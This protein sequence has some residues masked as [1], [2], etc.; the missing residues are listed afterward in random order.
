[1]AFIYLG[2][3]QNTSDSL[4][5]YH[6]LDFKDQELT[7]IS[8]ITDEFWLVN[9]EI[10]LIS[11]IW[12]HEEIMARILKQ[13]AIQDKLFRDFNGAVKSLDT[14]NSGFVMAVG[15]QKFKKIKKYFQSKGFH[16]V[17]SWDDLIIEN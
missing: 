4:M 6:N 11:R 9:D 3:K 2:K 17:F 12:E 15:K 13:I 8:G 1:M 5:N 10:D 14:W 7:R 16:T